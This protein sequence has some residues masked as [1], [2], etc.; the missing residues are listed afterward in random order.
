VESHL[1]GFEETVVGGRLEVRFLQRIRD[2]RKF[3]GVE[4]LRAQIAAD[5]ETSR[6]FFAE[7]NVAQGALQK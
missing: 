6:K 2:E 4:T 3:S 1:F 5:I 7:R